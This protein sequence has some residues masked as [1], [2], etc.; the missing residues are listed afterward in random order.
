MNL[1]DITPLEIRAMM[2][3]TTDPAVLR[4]LDKLEHAAQVDDLVLKVEAVS[5]LYEHIVLVQGMGL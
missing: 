1:F 3:D 2:E 4:A 5:D